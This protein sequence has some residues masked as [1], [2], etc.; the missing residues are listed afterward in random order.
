ME[1]K[2]VETFGFAV[3]FNSESGAGFVTPAV[4]TN[5][6]V[7]CH[8]I[9]GFLGSWDMQE[10]GK[11]FPGETEGTALCPKALEKANACANSQRVSF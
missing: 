1:Q 10:G 6:K 8:D 7:R 3:E 5:G 4:S 11:F 9:S 2:P